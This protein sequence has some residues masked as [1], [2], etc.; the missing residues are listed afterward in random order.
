MTFF[1]LPALLA[2]AAFTV[3][4]LAAAAQE[5]P[6]P[7]AEIVEARAADCASFENGELTLERGAVRRVDLNGDGT[8]DTVLDEGYLSCSSAAS[9]FCGTGGCMVNFLVGDT[10]E[11]RLAKGW[12]AVLFAPFTVVLA[13]VHGS[14]CG[15]TNVNT[16]VE[17]L[18]WDEERKAFNT[19]APPLQ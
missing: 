3:A 4:P 5:L 17:A 18:V 10:V 7:L 12:Q 6:A 9:L 19:V 14:E 1:K 8:L 15:G 2:C 13:Q 16:C 11:T